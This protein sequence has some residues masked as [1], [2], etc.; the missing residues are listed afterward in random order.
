MAYIGQRPGDASRGGVWTPNGI[1]QRIQR[2]LWDKGLSASNPIVSPADTANVRTGFV[3]VAPL[4]SSGAPFITYL[5]NDNFGGGWLLSWVVTNVSGDTTDWFDVGAS[6]NYFTT[7]T[8]LNSSSMNVLS[9]T[10][11]KNELFNVWSTSQIMILEDHNGTIGRKAYTLNSS[12]TFR[13]RFTATGGSSYSNQVSSIIGSSGSFSTFTTNTLMFNYA[14][15]GDGARLAATVA[16]GE[17]TGGISSRVDGGNSY[18][19]KGN[20]TRSDSNRGYNS[21]GTTTD[22]TVW[23]FVR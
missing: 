21:D 7:T 17:A 20:L 22:H 12:A 18:S 1:F 5:D 13:S 4:G 6:T 14:L 16:S 9:K 19:W 8:L 15:S 11:A 2:G 23:I 3:Y 10:N